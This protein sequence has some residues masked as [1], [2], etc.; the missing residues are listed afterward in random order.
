MKKSISLTVL[1]VL[2]L[3]LFTAIKL[4]CQDE[5]E[6]ES[7][8]QLIP[9]ED[10]I[11]PILKMA[12]KEY[13]G[14][15]PYDPTDTKFF[16]NGYEAKVDTTGSNGDIDSW[17]TT[18]LYV[19]KD[20]LLYFYNNIIPRDIYPENPTLYYTI[21]DI[22]PQYENYIKEFHAI[23][24]KYGKFRFV[25]KRA[26][27]PDT[28]PEIPDKQL[29]QYRCLHLEFDNYIPAMEVNNLLKS[30]D[31]IESSIF[32][33]GFSGEFFNAGGIVSKY[34][35]LPLYPSIANSYIKIQLSESD[36]LF[37]QLISIFDSNGKEVKQ[38]YTNLE[39]EQTIKVNNL[40]VGYYTIKVGNYVANFLIAR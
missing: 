18:R 20:Y 7:T 37:P 34:N 2:F 25:D 39:S 15:K 35:L 14:G 24:A 27:Y 12:Y 4:Q 40:P 8:P 17:M 23:E 16:H 10:Y 5:V 6:N 30:L 36:L 1:A 13:S 38:L 33:H 26:Q 11:R 22:L 32:L 28:L 29:R 9:L 19:K 31:F 21:D 3:S